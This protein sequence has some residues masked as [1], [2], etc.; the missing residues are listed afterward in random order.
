MWGLWKSVTQTPD[1]FRVSV[2]A[3]ASEE[4]V[5]SWALSPAEPLLAGVV[6]TMMRGQKFLGGQKLNSEE[7]IL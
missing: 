1:N 5:L 4:S 6:D 3:H 2:F 7:K